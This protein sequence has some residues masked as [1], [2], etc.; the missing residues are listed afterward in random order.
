MVIPSDWLGET[1]SSLLVPG[2]LTTVDME[3]LACYERSRIEIDHSLGNIG[4]FAHASD[5]M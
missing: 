1:A 5:R 3:N 2:A 4:N